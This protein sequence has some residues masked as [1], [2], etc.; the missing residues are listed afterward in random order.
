MAIPD[1]TRVRENLRIICPEAGPKEIDEMARGVFRNFGMY[2]V[3]FLRAGSLSLESV[4]EKVS[5]SKPEILEAALA[6]KRGAM[7]L[8]AHI[9]NWEIGGMALA[10]MGYPTAAIALNH[11]NP[12]VNNF[13]IQQRQRHG[14]EVIPF[15]FA[16]RRS[17]KAL[18][19]NKLLAILGDRNFNPAEGIE[20]ELF[21]KKLLLPRGPAW[22]SAHTGAALVPAFVLR[23]DSGGF[24]IQVHPE[25]APPKSDADGEVRRVIQDYA[26]VLEKVVRQDPA[27]WCIF[28]R[29]WE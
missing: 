2:L 15:G 10:L 13:F 20:I 12:R 3:D 6:R 26:S 7:I 21:G 4:K 1:R 14:I 19:E 23:Q 11:K 8:S 25:I 24:C 27:Q 17:L 18:K 29:F 22:L 9:G 28:H 5:I 16:L